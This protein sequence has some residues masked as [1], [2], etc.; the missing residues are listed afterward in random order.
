M[1]CSII[2]SLI[3]ILIESQNL[4]IP[5]VLLNGIETTDFLANYIANY[6]EASKSK[7]VNRIFGNLADLNKMLLQPIGRQVDWVFDKW[8][9]SP[10]V[11]D[12]KLF[13]EFK[14]DNPYKSF[15]EKNTPET[16]ERIGIWNLVSVWYDSSIK[17]RFIN[18]SS[19]N[20]SNGTN[21]LSY[22]KK[23][24]QMP[25]V[26]FFTLTMGSY[27]HWI[28]RKPPFDQIDY[29]NLY[30]ACNN[31]DSHVIKAN[32]ILNLSLEF[33]NQNIYTIFRYIPFE[34]IFSD[35]EKNYLFP[36]IAISELMDLYDCKVL[37]ISNNYLNPNVVLTSNGL[38]QAFYDLQWL[39]QTEIYRQFSQKGTITIIGNRII[40]KGQAIYLES[41]DLLCYVT[42]VSNQYSISEKTVTRSTTLTIERG[43]RLK[44]YD[45]YF[46]IVD[47]SGMVGV[48]ALDKKKDIN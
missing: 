19:F 48:D 31:N 43:I 16:Y 9:H 44:Y 7:S 22:L 47:F 27:F 28:I 3:S 35:N 2:Y 1:S 30:N 17:D 14:K 42:G 6:G 4:V 36:A 8:S 21:I 26:E 32:Q 25:M 5:N 18:D 37:E 20:N 38:R 10:F 11:S 13:N 29:I 23:I 33:D 12:Y 15:E 39:I 46:R 24:V 45:W 34:N 41:L 40:K